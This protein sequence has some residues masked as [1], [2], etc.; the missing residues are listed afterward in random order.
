MGSK[1]HLV[2]MTFFH[3]FYKYF[4]WIPFF[5]PKFILFY[6]NFEFIIWYQSPIVGENILQEP[7]HHSNHKN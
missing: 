5:A 7:T 6:F 1:V 3:I 2:K 4:K